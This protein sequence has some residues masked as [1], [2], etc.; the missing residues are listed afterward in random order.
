MCQGPLFCMLSWDLSCRPGLR[1]GEPKI[2]LIGFPPKLPFFLHP[3]LW[4]IPLLPFSHS[5]QST[6]V[7]LAFSLFSHPRQ[8]SEFYRFSFLDVSWHIFSS[9]ASPITFSHYF[10][11]FLLLAC[12]PAQPL[13]C[14]P[15]LVLTGTGVS[16]LKYISLLKYKSLLLQSNLDTP[17]SS[18]NT[19]YKH[20]YYTIWYLFYPQIAILSFLVCITLKT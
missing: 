3:F 16:F 8:S 4:L 10:R 1:L 6:A 20:L 18:H 15:C 17:P 14:L 5:H 11:L 7:V 9:I 19:L 13:S 12:I 2:N